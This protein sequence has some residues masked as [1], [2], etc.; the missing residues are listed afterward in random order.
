MRALLAVVIFGITYVAIAT[1]RVPKHISALLGA[2]LLMTTGVLN[3]D[4]AIHYVSWDTIGLLL[5][6]FILIGMLADSGFFG[7]MAARVAVSLNYSPRLV[8]V[9]FPL[10]AAV[11][12]AF[13][14]SI[15]V[16]MFMVALSTD[17]ASILEVD[18]VPLVVAEV[19]AANIGGAST[20][21]GDPPNVI[22]GSLLGYGFSDFLLNTGP[23]SLVSLIV[24]LCYFLAVTRREYRA[25]DPTRLAELR[26]RLEAFESSNAIVSRRMMNLGLAGLIIAVALLIGHGYIDARL[27][28]GISPAIASMLPALVV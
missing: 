15:T 16:T 7:C 8:I 22:L 26:S 24:T 27:H 3:L 13:M 14:D 17:L 10:L 6:M 2:V 5:G 18:P 9:V 12:S 23:I 19:C 20:L 1:E 25:L 21:V 11:L 28:L 4:Q